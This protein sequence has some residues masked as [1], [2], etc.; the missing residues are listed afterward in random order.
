MSLWPS[1]NAN[2]CA[3]TRII[4]ISLLLNGV[5]SLQSL[6]VSLLLSI[7]VE[8]V[9]RTIWRSFRKFI[10]CFRCNY[11]KTKFTIAIDNSIHEFWSQNT[12]SNL[13]TFIG[14]QLFWI[15]VGCVRILASTIWV[16][17]FYSIIICQIIPVESSQCV[18]FVQLSRSTK[19]VYARTRLQHI[20]AMQ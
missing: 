3:L 1:S 2:L 4:Y 5:I 6:P 11:S 10:A 13:I 18:E 20:H 8:S 7:Y 16:C 12:R 9:A 19:Y 14:H 15:F 17:L